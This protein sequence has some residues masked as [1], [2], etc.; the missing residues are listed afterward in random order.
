MRSPSK[1][2]TRVTPPAP[3]GASRAI[4]ANSSR[5]APSQTATVSVTFVA[6]SV[7]TNGR[8]PPAASQNPATAPDGSWVDDGETA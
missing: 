3:G 2:G 8:K 4:S 6:L 5:S 7:H 1:Y